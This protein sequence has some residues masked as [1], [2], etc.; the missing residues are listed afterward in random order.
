MLGLAFQFL[1]DALELPFRLNEKSG[2]ANGRELSINPWI[3]FPQES[4]AF[5]QTNMLNLNSC[6]RQLNCTHLQ[7]ELK[8]FFNLQKKSF[9]RKMNLIENFDDL[10]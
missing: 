2:E 3:T 7:N 8:T 9:P 1:D 5:F 10:F 4:K 6:L